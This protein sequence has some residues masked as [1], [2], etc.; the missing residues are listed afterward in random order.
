MKKTK[1]SKK[2]Y[3]NI[4]YRIIL[5]ILGEFYE[6]TVLN[7][8]NDINVKC[9]VKEYYGRFKYDFT[10]KIF[11][12]FKTFEYGVFK[13]YIHNYKFSFL[14]RQYFPK[15]LKFVFRRHLLCSLPIPNRWG[16]S[17]YMQSKVVSYNLKK[18]SL[19]TKEYIYD[20]VN[21]L[22]IYE[23]IKRWKEERII[24]YVKVVSG[25]FWEKDKKFFLDLKLTE[26]DFLKPSP[27][28]CNKI[29]NLKEIEYKFCLCEISEH[30]HLKKGT[31]ITFEK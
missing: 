26:K 18:G 24:K 17:R 13:K 25:V 22:N 3:V 14:N 28:I 19:S 5:I 23:D 30:L 11:Q 8:Y 21:S 20:Y 6:Y 16:Y 10:K 31:V 15:I 4:P 29:V 1:V 7:R 12:I 27:E 2:S 9:E